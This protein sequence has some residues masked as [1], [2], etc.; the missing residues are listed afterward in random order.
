MG[1]RYETTKASLI[2]INYNGIDCVV[3]CLKALDQQLLREFEIVLVDNGSSDGSVGQIEEFLKR[4]QLAHSIKLVPCKSNLGFAGGGLEGL[5]HTNGEYIALLNNDT[6]ADKE[7]LGE[8]VKAMDMNPEIGICGS[9]MILR[10]TDI[11][12]SAGDGVSTALRGFKRGE[13]NKASLYSEREYVFGACAGAAL[14][15]RKMIEEIGFLDEDF[16][17]IHED[18]DLNFRAQLYGWKVLYVP[19]AIVYHKVRSSIG[20]MS[21][22]AVYYTLRNSELVRMK[23]VPIPIL[24]RCL[25]EFVSGMLTEFIYFAIMHKCLRLYF[26]AKID[27]MRMLRKMLKKR[28]VIMENRKVNCKYL[29]GIMTPVWQKDFLMSKIKKFLYA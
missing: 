6:E 1:A 28:A 7:W 27:A 15:R 11:I 25:P 20:H 9:R 22:A 19:T 12:D 10:G 29:L 2:V 24:L 5:R 8:M 23:N 26:R 14:Y 13:G 4:N 18:T 3:N 17:L 16:F 21:D